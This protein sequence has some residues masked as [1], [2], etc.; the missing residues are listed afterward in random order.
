MTTEISKEGLIKVISDLSIVNQLVETIYVDEQ[1]GKVDISKTIKEG[2]CVKTIDTKIDFKLKSYRLISKNNS[3]SNIV[4]SDSPIDKTIVRNKSVYDCAIS[5]MNQIFISELKSFKKIQKHEYKFFNQSLLKRIF[6][7]N[8]KQDLIEHIIELGSNCSWVIV[9]SYIMDIISKSDLFEYT[10]SNKNSMLAQV[11]NLSNLSIY[12]NMNEDESVLYF[13]NYDS[14]IILL[15]KNLQ[16]NNVRS[17]SSIY[18][19]ETVL[20]LDYLMVEN[21]DGITKLL[22]I[23]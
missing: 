3:Y 2:Y 8:T 20:S 14:M 17:L 15:N 18:N 12:V 7:K 16:V 4:I 6:N 11:G 9:P 1:K 5:D 23:K 22:T 10:V 13:G 19:N 21:E